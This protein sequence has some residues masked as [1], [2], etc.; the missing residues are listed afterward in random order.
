MFHS[1]VDG[2]TLMSMW[3]AKTGPMGAILTKED[4]KQGEVGGWAERSEYDH[5][6]VSTIRMQCF[7]NQGP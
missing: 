5:S 1:P 2:L 4:M 6:R 7:M 3:T